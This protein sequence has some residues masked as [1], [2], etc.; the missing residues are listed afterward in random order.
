MNR[1]MYLTLSDKLTDNE[2][3]ATA[4]EINQVQPNEEKQK[5][6]LLQVNSEELGPFDRN[7]NP[8]E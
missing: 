1:E 7:S 6:S 5:N 3:I 8:F 2:F 4:I